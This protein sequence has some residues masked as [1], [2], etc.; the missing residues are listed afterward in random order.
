M[1]SLKGY[2]YFHRDVTES[3]KKL[4]GD[5]TPELLEAKS[6]DDVS[7]DP[8]PVRQRTQQLPGAALWA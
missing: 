8:T 7:D 1:K 5:T 4:I 6:A 2:R 3:E